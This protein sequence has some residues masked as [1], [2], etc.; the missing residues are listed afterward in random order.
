MTAGDGAARC[1]VVI[2]KKV[3]RLANRLLLYAHFIGAAVEHGFSVVNLS[4]D[5]YASLFPATAR[6][7]LC[8]YP[9]GRRL[10]P[11][12]GGRRLLYE[13]ATVAADRRHRRQVGGKDVGLIRLRRDEQLDLNSDAFVDVIRRHRVVLVQDWFFRSPEN[14]ARHRNPICAHLTPSPAVLDRASRAVEPI[15]SR[16]R[17]AVGVHIRQT[18]YQTFK[19]G[20]HYYTHEQYRAVMEQVQTAFPERDVTFLV[21]SD[22]D[23]PAGVFDGLDVVRGPGDAAGDLYALARC[24]RLVGPPSSFSAWASYYGSVPLC[25]IEDPQAR[26]EAVSFR[27]R[28]GL[29]HGIGPDR[30]A[31]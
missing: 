31:G 9:C 11:V 10:W 21:C 12:P 16:D 7:L 23:V 8:R 22:V 19:G 26:I 3:G 20:R 1:T 6:D 4:F 17:L 2:A 25:W 30:A 28:E 14:C 5:P 15:R 27:V 24:D 29:S 13:V 18:D